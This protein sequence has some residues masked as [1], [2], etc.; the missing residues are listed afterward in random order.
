MIVLFYGGSGSGKSALAE[1]RVM[2]L[3]KN[4]RYYLATMQVYGEEGRQKVERHRK[5]RETKDFTTV[6]KTNDIG[7]CIKDKDGTVLLECVSNLVANEMFLPEEILAKEVV[8]ERVMQGIQTLAQDVKNLVIVSN[9][10]FEDWD[11]YSEETENY[12]QALGL[13]NQQIAA[14]SD[15]VMEAVAGCSVCWKSQL[16]KNDLELEK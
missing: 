11:S 12:R 10:I 3:S 14:M 5:M 13:V 16:Q 8:V 15:E 6:E 7:G 2:E 4:H 1:A 9:N